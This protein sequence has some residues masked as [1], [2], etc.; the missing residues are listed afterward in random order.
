MNSTLVPERGPDNRAIMSQQLMTR[1]VQG[2]SAEGMAIGPPGNQQ[3]YYTFPGTGQ[4][5][6]S[7][8]DLALLVTASLNEGS[9]DPQLRTAL[10]AT[11]REVFR[12]D[13]QNAQATA[14]EINNLG[15]S[16]IIDKPG[17]LNNASAY[18]GLVPEQKLGIVILCNRGDVYPH[19]IARR[20]LL[21]E[22]AS[23]SRS[24]LP[25]P[26]H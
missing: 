21:P 23:Y 26:G 1:T 25:F 12:V 15:G 18:L 5:F 14:W 6:S 16:T 11:Q 24:L 2:Y 13:A 17:G 7:A 22:L 3:S 8:R 20:T 19:E 9:S 4:M 10:Q